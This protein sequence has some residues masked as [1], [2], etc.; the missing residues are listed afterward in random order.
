MSHTTEITNVVFKDMKALSLAVQEI[1]KQTRRDITLQK[2]AK[3]RAYYDN[4]QGMGI[5]PFV[6]NLGANSYDIGLYEGKKKGEYTAKCDFFDRNIEKLFGVECPPGKDAN[7]ARLGKLYQLYSVHATMRQ[8]A[9]QGRQ[10]ERT[11]ASDGS[12]QLCVS[13]N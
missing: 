1:A 2:N 9:M 8:A 5:A 11:Q 10:V 6:I 13:V 7:Q 4:Q 3:P 12:I